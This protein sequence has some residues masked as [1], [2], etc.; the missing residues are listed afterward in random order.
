[1]GR[2]TG[3]GGCCWADDERGLG[4]S[5]DPIPLLL[6]PAAADVVVVVVVVVPCCCCCCCGG[7]LDESGDFGEVSSSPLSRE[8]VTAVEKDRGGGEICSSVS[9]DILFFFFFEGY[10][11]NFKLFYFLWKPGIR[12]REKKMVSFKKTTCINEKGQ[13]MCLY[14]VLLSRRCSSCHV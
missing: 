3:V 4:G 1:M 13:L 10:P 11:K 7:L 14:C 5:E 2:V 6:L 8:G 9:C 12:K